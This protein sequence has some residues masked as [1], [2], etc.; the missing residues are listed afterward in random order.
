M[1]SKEKDYINYSGPHNNNHSLDF[2]SISQTYM[3]HAKEA[4]ISFSI[5]SDFSSM[6][7]KGLSSKQIKFSN[8]W[9]FIHLPVVFCELI[10][11]FSVLYVEFLLGS[12]AV[13]FFSCSS[14]SFCPVKLHTPGSFAVPC[15]L[16]SLPTSISVLAPCFLSHNE[17]LGRQ[18]QS[19]PWKKVKFNLVT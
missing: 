1:Q 13:A 17:I 18:N 10:C 6:D 11:A 14:C 8:C 2:I 12:W 15:L 16:S 3:L 4:N 19:M 9:I 7:L 5:H